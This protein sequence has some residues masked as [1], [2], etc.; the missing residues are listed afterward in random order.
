VPTHGQWRLR[1]AP[2]LVF[3]PGRPSGSCLRQKLKPAFL[4]ADPE[5]SP[6]Q[7]AQQTTEAYQS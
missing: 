5:F 6:R 3:T 1:A 7:D 2:T 4:E